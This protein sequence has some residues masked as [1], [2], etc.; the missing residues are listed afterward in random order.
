MVIKMTTRLTPGTNPAV[1]DV[2]YT[3]D[4]TATRI[5][6]HFIGKVRGKRI[7]DPCRG[8]GAFYNNFPAGNTKLWCEI[9]EGRDFFRHRDPV[10]WII[11]GPPWS[12]PYLRPMTK[13]AMSLANDIVWLVPLAN[14]VLRARLEDMQKRGFGLKEVLTLSAA[15]K[16]PGYPQSGF[17]LAAVHISKSFNGTTK[18]SGHLLK[19]ANDN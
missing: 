15:E 3:D 17:Q 18:W 5:I 4:A 12:A 8:A 13:H 16:P 11:S 1:R 9:S 19:A 6:N 10:D 14:V 2:V 7:L